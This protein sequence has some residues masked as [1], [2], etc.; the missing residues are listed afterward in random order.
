M[1]V[2]L[3]DV[4]LEA[5]VSKATVSYVINGKKRSIGI[6]PKTVEKV[7]DVVERLGY[8]PN[9][10]AVTLGR[11]RGRKPRILV[12]SPWRH[13]GSSQFMIQVMKAME[14][15]DK[16]ARMNFLMFKSG[17]LGKT[18]ERLTHEVHDTVL[19]M[20]TAPK[21]DEFLEKLSGE[22]KNIVMLN[23]KI[24]GVA[25]VH[26]DDFGGGARVGE[27]FVESSC[28]DEHVFVSEKDFSQVVR[29]RYDGFVQALKKGGV[30]KPARFMLTSERTASLETQF[31]ALVDARGKG[32][33]LFFAS[34]D[35]LATTLMTWLMKEGENVPGKY[36]VVGYD[37]D[38]VASIVRPRLTT[39]NSKTFSMA[40]TA[41]ELCVDSKR[42]AD[43]PN[44]V[45]EPELVVR[46]SVSLPSA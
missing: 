30:E 43:A 17:S 22:K 35:V 5:G 36:G 21:D 16:R 8:T 37:D 12:L 29:D 9:S 25:S 14:G 39:V 15:F 3:D 32:K 44:I 18:F 6:S 45:V 34:K 33:T 10:A 4:A 46:E 28:Y 1:K 2:T 13:L 19:I 24:K 7:R 20:G 31:K 40:K 27:L 41:L 42:L 38:P 26:G 11:R 23:R